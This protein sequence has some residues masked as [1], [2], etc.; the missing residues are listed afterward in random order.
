MQNCKDLISPPNLPDL[1]RKML[2]SS[3]L[4]PVPHSEGNLLPAVWNRSTQTWCVPHNNQHTFPLMPLPQGLWPPKEQQWSNQGVTL[5]LWLGKCDIIDSV[6][7]P[8][9]PFLWFFDC[10]SR[11][12]CLH[13]SILLCWLPARVETSA[14]TTFAGGE[15]CFQSTPNSVASIAAWRAGGS[16]F[17]SKPPCYQFVVM[18]NTRDQ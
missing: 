2:Q 11:S 17:F 4:V 14:S 6:G 3:G 15:L 1:Q 9:F 18:G 16:V 8:P 10:Q 13:S 7:T 5:S 12:R